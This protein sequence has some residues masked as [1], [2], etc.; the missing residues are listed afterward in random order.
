[1][2]G[3]GCMLKGC[4]Y[5]RISLLAM[6]KS[7]PLLKFDKSEKGILADEGLNLIKAVSGPV[8]PV[9]FIGDG[10]G[11]KSYL[12]SRLAGD[13]EAFTSSDS[14]EPVTEGIDVVIRPVSA[15][16]E[17]LG[18]KVDPSRKDEQLLILDCEGGNNAMAAIR[19]LVN[20]FGIIIGT[21]VVFVSSGM[22]SEQALQ[23]LGASLAASSIL[24]LKISELPKR[25]LL[26]VVNKN[27]LRY[28]D[29]ALE[30]MLEVKEG[31]DEGR[32]DVRKSILA[33]FEDVNRKF[34]AV[35]IKGMPNFEPAVASIRKAVLDT[36]V[37]LT[38][39][40]VTVVGPSLAGLLDKIV[41]EMRKQNEVS[42]P[43]MTKFVVYDGFL[44]PTADRMVKK[45]TDEQFPKLDDYVDNLDKLDPRKDILQAFEKEVAYIG[46]EKLIVDAKRYLQEKLDTHW[47]LVA[48]RNKAFGEEVKSMETETREVAAEQN[49]GP[50]GGKGLLR[51][52]VVTMQNMRI[53]SRPL[54]YRRKGGEPERGTWT[55]TGTETTRIKES[56]FEVY[57]V[58]PVLRGHLSKRSPNL[59]RK[60]MKVAGMHAQDRKC[61]LK[62]AH[63]LWWEPDKF[64]GKNEAAGCINFLI[65]RATCTVD[66]NNPTSFIIKPAS[67]EGWKDTTSF[68]GNKDR[69]FWFDASDKEINCEEWVRALKAHIDFANQAYEQLGEEKIINQVGIFKP[70]LAQVDC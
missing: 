24:D 26:F 3:A 70:N 9:I 1:M 56:A 13:D 49:M 64:A 43:S 40:G 35:P 31:M 20:V 17:E 58:L 47:E 59:V 29:D 45:A 32:A 8:C 39:G 21:Q 63:F 18:E 48:A 28:E 46:D 22:A 33:N 53:E 37:P 41:G 15:I 66:E 65:N 14:A 52:V 67:P 36:R 69:Q 55:D 12:A 27:T 62:D 34:F 25:G 6:S 38:M 61:I 11:G 23:T 10:R 44:I 7:V 54:I 60:A 50:I 68:T 51:R 5:V 19:T 4:D 2:T 57:G 16:L 30:K 42:F